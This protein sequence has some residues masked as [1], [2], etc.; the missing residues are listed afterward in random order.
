M[1]KLLLAVMVVYASGTAV[2][3]VR[4]TEN[5]PVRT[6]DTSKVS[7]NRQVSSNNVTARDNAPTTQVVRNQA[8]LSGNFSISSEDSAGV[9]IITDRNLSVRSFEGRVPVQQMNV[10]TGIIKTKPAKLILS[11]KQPKLGNASLRFGSADINFE[12]GKVAFSYRMDPRN[13]I[14]ESSSENFSPMEGEFWSST[15]SAEVVKLDQ[16]SYEFFNGYVGAKVSFQKNQKYLIQFWVESTKLIDYTVWIG[17]NYKEVLVTSSGVASLPKP[18]QRY[19]YSGQK[20]I[21]IIV[22]PGDYEGD[23]YVMLAGN[24]QHGSWVFDRFEMTTIE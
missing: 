17:K 8:V 13:I 7:T 9:F 24:F 11:S 18:N 4:R 20:K 14:K 12:T 6:R 23:Y 15:S 5:P 22:E 21:S 2:A 19:F 16:R 10:I 3:Q 1:K